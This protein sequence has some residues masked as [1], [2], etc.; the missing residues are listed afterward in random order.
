MF[1][2]HNCPC[3]LEYVLVLP[4]GYSI[5]L[6]CVSPSK[7]LPDSFLPKVCCE[8]VGEVLFVAVRLKA[9]HMKNGCLFDFVLELLEVREHFTLLLHREYLGVLGEVVDECHLVPASLECCRLG[10]SPHI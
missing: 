10:W 8:G 4:F 3:H 9:P 2:I 6:R 5:L 1:L 7:L